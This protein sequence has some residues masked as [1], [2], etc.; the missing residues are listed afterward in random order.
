MA[1]YVEQHWG[2]TA[3]ARRKRE[4]NFATH[5]HLGNGN[6]E[7]ERYKKTSVEKVEKSVEGFMSRTENGKKTFSMLK[8]T[9]ER[10]KS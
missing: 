7:T 8:Q 4:Q 5:S 6:V 3:K 1:L 9:E 10:T 2:N